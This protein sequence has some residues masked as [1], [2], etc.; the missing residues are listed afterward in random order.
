MAIIMGKIYRYLGAGKG[1]IGKNGKCANYCKFGGSKNRE[2]A[3][4]FGR[5]RDIRDL[6]RNFTGVVERKI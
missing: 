2:L 6:D 3:I 1:S 4:G 5:L